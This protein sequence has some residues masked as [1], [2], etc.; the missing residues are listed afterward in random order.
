MSERFW[1]KV[2]RRGDDECW[3]WTAYRNHTGYGVLSNPGKHQGTTLAH[4]FSFE[5]HV[6]PVPDGLCVLHRCDNPPCCNP[7]HFFL[8]TRDDNNK[9]RTLKG[10]GR[11]PRGPAHAKAKLTEED[12]RQIRAMAALGIETTWMAALFPCNRNSINHIRAG[13]NWRHVA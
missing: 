6:G 8:G 3:P 11:A 13:R 10:R 12:V 1:S 7:K 4:R 2:E 5:L 9:D